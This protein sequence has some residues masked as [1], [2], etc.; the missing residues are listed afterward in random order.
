MKT[1]SLSRLAEIRAF[2]DTEVLAVIIWNTGEREEKRF[3]RSEDAWMFLASRRKQEANRRNKAAR[4]YPVF[5]ASAG[6]TL[7]GNLF[8]NTEKECSHAT[9]GTMRDILEGEKKRHAELN[10]GEMEPMEVEALWK[11]A[12]N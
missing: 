12:K 1:Y 8:A 9:P 6:C 7:G 10:L 4:R 2:L 5:A 3:S 11:L